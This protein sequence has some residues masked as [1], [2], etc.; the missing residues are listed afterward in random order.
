MHF[1]TIQS[2][3]MNYN[4]NLPS[5]FQS[6]K[7]ILF[8]VVRSIGLHSKLFFEQ[9]IDRL[10]CF[11]N[12]LVC[13]KPFK[14]LP[15]E[16]PTGAPVTIVIQCRDPLGNIRSLVSEKMLEKLPCVCKFGDNGCQVTPATQIGTESLKTRR[17]SLVVTYP[18]R[19]NSF[20]NSKLILK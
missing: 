4:C 14:M 20:A 9:K 7:T 18:L 1:W 15:K 17:T 19:A 13:K 5:N 2:H 6:M 12:L 11:L 8:L 10:Y 16:R 3:T